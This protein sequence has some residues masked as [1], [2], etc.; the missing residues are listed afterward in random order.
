[1]NTHCPECHEPVDVAPHAREGRCAWCRPIRQHSRPSHLDW[2]DH[3]TKFHKF[4]ADHQRQIHH[5][6]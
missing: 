5:T 1:M 6:R 4:V 2:R 3:A